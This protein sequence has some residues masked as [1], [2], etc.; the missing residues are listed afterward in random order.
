MHTYRGYTL[1]AVRMGPWKCHYQTQPGY[2]QPK[3]ESHDPPILFNLEVDPS[4]KW[5]LAKKHPEILEVI[6][7]R[8]ELHKAKMVFAKSQL[9]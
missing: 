8:V 1:M 6:R 7:Q 2:G 5:D 4:K 9:D 3:A